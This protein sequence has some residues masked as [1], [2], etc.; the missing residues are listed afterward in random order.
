VTSLG[1]WHSFLEDVAVWFYWAG[2]A[3]GAAL[4]P[5]ILLS[6]KVAQAKV[7][8]ILFVLGFPWVGAFF[9][10]ALGRARLARSVVRLRGRRG[11]A[12]ARVDETLRRTLASGPPISPA[13]PAE[14]MVLGARHVGATPAVAGNEFTLLA[15]GPSAFAAGHEAVARAKHHVHLLIY[16]FK[17]DRTG[18]E[19][20][21]RLTDAVRR[22][23]E[24]RV[25]FDGLG[26][27]RTKRSFFAPFR[28]AGGRVSTF[29][30][31]R[32]IASGL[33]L[34]LR[35]HRKL[36]LVDGET[37]FLGGM[38]VGDEY[39]TGK[40]WHDLLGRIRGP[41]VP[42]LQRVFVE[43][44][45]FATGELLDRD[46][47]FPRPAPAGDVPVQVVASGPD[48][49]DPQ[50]EERMFSALAAADKSVDI[51]TPYLVPTEPLVQ[52]IVSAAR[53]G[54]RVR[55]LLPERVD[56][57]VVRW[58]TDAYVPRLIQRGVEVWRHRTNLDM[59]S[60]R[61]TFEL[62]VAMPHAGTAAVLT[63]YFEGELAGARRLTAA[64]FETSLPRRLL[65]AGAHLLGPV[66]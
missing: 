25:L 7:A 32:P 14:Q 27:I 41:V 28:A 22:G 54:R 53:R 18:K 4:V 24:V 50:A 33:R 30:P 55:I 45:H 49:E 5:G 42:A 61:L 19:V 9:Y 29:L 66:L 23:V 10:G 52:A 2:L 65:H 48:Q 20:L 59:R 44:W 62:N 37:A 36:L 46:E 39:A 12:L 64:D 17:D 8:W 13:D 63:R 56:H 26:T 57:R 35:N 6:R 60:L 31:F 1:A 11:A 47:Y 58:A 34:N 38:N 43:D 15:D 51:L 16:I 3:L 40:D 21:E